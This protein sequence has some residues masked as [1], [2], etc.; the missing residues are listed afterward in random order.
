[1]AQQPKDRLR[2]R[3][4]RAVRALA[5]ARSFRAHM[6]LTTGS[7]ILLVLL[8]VL[9]GALAARLLGPTGRGQLAAIQMW[10]NFLAVVG[11]LGLPDALVYYSA[12][13]RADCGRYLGSA[14]SLNLLVSLAFMAL[15]NAAFPVLLGAQEPQIV[16]AARWYLLL[17]PVQALWLPY[18][19]FRGRSD[20][21]AWNAA[22]FLASFGW[23]GLLVFGSIIGWSTPAFLALAY[24]TVLAV[25]AIPVLALTRRS[26]PPPY[27]PDPRQWGPMLRF[28]LPSV[29]SGV[30]RALNLRLDQMLMAAL[31]P[32][33]TLG[34]YVVAVTWSNAVGPLPNA[35]ANV[36]FPQTAATSDPEAR[37]QVFATGIR[38]AVLSSVSIA[39]V[40]AMITPWTLPL[41]FGPAFAA[42][43]RPALVLV[44]AAAID[45]VNMVLEEGLRGLGRPGLVLRAELCGLAVTAIALCCCSAPSASWSRSGVRSRVQR[46]ARHSGRHEPGADRA[47]PNRAPVSRPRGDRPDLA[48]IPANTRPT[49]SAAGSRARDQVNPI[50]DCAHDDPCLRSLLPARVQI[51]WTGEEHRQPRRPSRSRP[52]FRHRHLGSR[53]GRCCPL[54]RYLPR[55]T[56]PRRQSGRVLRRRGTDATR[57][58]C[59]TG[60]RHEA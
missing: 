8:G 11:N 15:G 60:A 22:R 2:G 19:C 33:Q 41:L 59:R 23:L 29:T 20:F 32:V 26:I 57:P 39:V 21:A 50:Q 34:L 46:R 45:A 58:H 53:L 6:L 51:R 27:R 54:P 30:P 14:V 1:M 24:L 5:T 49:V 7:N 37:R 12:R 56:A 40:V 48:V 55:G 18:H 36:L 42:A 17:L 43:V 52:A 10:P 38:L 4:G 28:G 44:G 13:A 16:S 31:L 25:L 35:L 9:T 3:A 47:Q